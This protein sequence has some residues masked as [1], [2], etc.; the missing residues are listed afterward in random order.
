MSNKCCKSHFS[1]QKSLKKL[2]SEPG[3]IKRASPF[4]ILGIKELGDEDLIF[5]IFPKELLLYS[6]KVYSPR[7]YMD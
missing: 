6:G 7:D 3:R 4:E 5:P 1:N 2:T